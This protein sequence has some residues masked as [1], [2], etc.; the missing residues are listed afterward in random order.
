MIEWVVVE[1]STSLAQNLGYG[2]CVYTRDSHKGLNLVFDPS[3]SPH[4]KVVCIWHF[5]HVDSVLSIDYDRNK[6]C[7]HIEIYSSET[8][9]WRACVEP[10]IANQ[11]S[12][13]LGGVYWNG[14]IN[15]FNTSGDSLYFNLH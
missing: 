1:V 6:L 2:I 7:Y 3:R 11:N 4:Y 15:R 12:E 14:A 10:F 9:S 5:D 13:F 8:G